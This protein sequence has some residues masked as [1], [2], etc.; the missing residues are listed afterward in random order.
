MVEQY[1]L[2]ANEQDEKGMVETWRDRKKTFAEAG[3]KRIPTGLLGNRQEMRDIMRVTMSKV[4]EAL[5]SELRLK[6][7][8][9]R[10]EK[11]GNLIN[12]SVISPTFKRKDDMKRQVMIRDALDKVFGPL[13][14]KRVG[15]IL[16]YT[17]DEW[18]PFRDRIF[19]DEASLPPICRK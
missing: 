12:G 3:R 18:N 16:A 15:M 19:G 11:W 13:A 14:D 17:P 2:C 10:L 4:R 1:A 7:P 9:F 8:R 5:I 6:E